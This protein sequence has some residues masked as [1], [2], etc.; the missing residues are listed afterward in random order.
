M[1]GFG[2]REE[3]E[4]AVEACTKEGAAGVKHHGADL[5]NPEQIAGLFEFARRKFG[6]TPDIVVNNAG[7]SS[8]CCAMHTCCTIQGCT[9]E[10]I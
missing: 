1:N 2:S 4:S 10:M 8:K 6:R 3:V 7:D 5:S 9:I